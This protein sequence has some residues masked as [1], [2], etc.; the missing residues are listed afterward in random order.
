MRH[1]KKVIK[2]AHV[3]K[4]ERIALKHNNIQKD[5]TE[6]APAQA[7]KIRNATQITPTSYNDN[8]LSL[9]IN[10][11]GRQGI[12]SCPIYKWFHSNIHTSRM[13]SPFQINFKRFKITF[14]FS[15]LDT[16]IQEIFELKPM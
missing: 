10:K 15:I 4:I 6:C 16:T 13:M 11:R 2:K 7:S 9:I 8:A 12:I 5:Q 14:Y 1:S 3:K